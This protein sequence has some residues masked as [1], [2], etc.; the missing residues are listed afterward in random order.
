MVCMKFELIRVK[1]T[2]V[3]DVL[4]PEANIEGFH[5]ISNWITLTRA[6]YLPV[7]QSSK[8][9]VHHNFKMF[10]QNTPP[11]HLRNDGG[12]EPHH[13]NT[14][15]SSCCHLVWANPCSPPPAGWCLDV[16]GVAR[17]GRGLSLLLPLVPPTSEVL[18]PNDL[19]QKRIEGVFINLAVLV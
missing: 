18:E 4:I 16:R 17:A 6:G 13:W 1:N 19:R 11:R 14:A 12:S 2:N 5:C 8:V 7:V 9:L 10:H 3:Q 15:K